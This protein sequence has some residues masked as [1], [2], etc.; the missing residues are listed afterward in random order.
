[1]RNKKLR[2]SNN[3]QNIT[4]IIIMTSIILALIAGGLAFFLNNNNN[5]GKNNMTDTILIKTNMGDITV[6]LNRTAAPITVT[7]F[8]TYVNEDFF[9]GTIFHRVIKDFMIQ[10]GGFTPD[11]KQK[12]TKAGI[13]LESQNGLSNTRG[14]IA[15]ARTNDPNSATAQFFINTVD[16][17]FLDYA[18]G[19]PGY[20]VFG[21]VT[22]G[23][24]VVDAIQNVQT[25][26]KPMPDW[27]VDAVIIQSIEKVN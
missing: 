7:N 15:M 18:P 8:L 4:K 10:G 21:K 6:E 2:N 25:T 9:N 13:K 3:K 22:K 5:Q 23:M 26:S 16:N 20:A 14:T 11:G 17:K 1:M 27:P 12:K 24:D 19:N